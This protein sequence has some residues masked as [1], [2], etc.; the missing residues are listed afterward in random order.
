MPSR[1]TNTKESESPRHH[2]R[3]YDSLQMLYRNLLYTAVTRG[4]KLVVL[5][6]TK[7]ALSIAVTSHD[8]HKRFTGLEKALHDVL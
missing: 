7:K 6:G 2:P 5:V 4:K 8:A 1:S 3:P